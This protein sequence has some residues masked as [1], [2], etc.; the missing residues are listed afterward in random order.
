V[1]ILSLLLVAGLVGLVFG[2]DWFVRGA[3]SL[4]VAVGVSPLV[5]G[6]TV[7]AYGTSM[8]ELV[9]SGVAALDGRSAI[10]LGNVIGSNIANVGLILGLT[11]LLA[12][13]TVDGTLQRRELPVFLASALVVPL[14]LV[15]GTVGRVEALALLVGAIAFTV[16]TARRQPAA[17]AMAGDAAAEPS[18]SPPDANGRVGL[19]RASA[20]TIVGLALLLGGGRLFVNAAS[21][22]ATRAGISERV[23][24]ITVVAVG[25]SLPELAASAVAAL[26]GLSSLAIGNVVGSN[27]FNVLFVLGG[28]GLIA[29]VRGELALLR[30]DLGVMVG[31]SLA[32][33]VLLRAPRRVP[34]VE[35]A[36]L[37]VGY[38]AAMYALTIGMR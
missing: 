38:M 24:G 8:P 19:L 14:L 36:L 31:F 26:R 10:A 32:A 16:V 11:A 29:P 33:A 5:I 35:G 1:L 6:L 13:P 15:D 9:V 34:R 20:L 22:L 4:A 37:I 7:V 30:F 12:P 23:I 18:A 3:A 21:E 17:S 28:A 25:T 2:A 27:I